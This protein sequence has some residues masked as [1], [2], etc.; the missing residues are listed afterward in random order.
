MAYNKSDSA[1]LAVIG[2]NIANKV[3]PKRNRLKEAA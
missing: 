1:Y 3:I 2:Y